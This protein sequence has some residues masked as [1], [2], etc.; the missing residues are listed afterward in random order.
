MN[1]PASYI[2]FLPAGSERRHLHG[3]KEKEKEEEK[4]VK[5]KRSQA[6]RRIQQE[7]DQPASFGECPLSTLR[8]VFLHVAVNPGAEFLREFP[9]RKLF[10]VGVSFRFFLRFPESRCFFSGVCFRRFFGDQT[11]KFQ[12]RLFERRTL[13]R[14]AVDGFSGVHCGGDDQRRR[15]KQNQRECSRKG[16]EHGSG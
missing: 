1:A 13:C 14:P 11:G 2:R 16:N 6:R 15:G 7:S 3:E 8:T 5:R 9:E 4:Q 10:P 12:F